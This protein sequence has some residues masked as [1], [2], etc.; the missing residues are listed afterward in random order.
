MSGGDGVSVQPSA[1]LIELSH[2]WIVLRASENVHH[3]VSESH[4]TL[5]DE[6]LGRFMHSQALHDLRNLFSRLSGTTGIAR[7]YR[8]RLT[9]RHELFDIA[10]HDVD[11]RVLLE[12]VPSP[13]HGL[14]EAFGIVGGLIEGLASATGTA[15]LEG[16]ARRMRA[17]TGFDRVTLLYGGKRAVS[18][19]GEFARE[20]SS[21]LALPPIIG[22]CGARAVPL[23]PRARSRSSAASALLRAAPREA[24]DDLVAAGIGA[25]DRDRRTLST[26]GDEESVAAPSRRERRPAAVGDDAQQP[27]TEITSAVVRRQR[28]ERAHQRILEHVFGIVAAPEHAGRIAQANR[29]V[30]VDEDRERVRIACQRPRDNVRVVHH[31]EAYPRPRSVVT[32]TARPVVADARCIER[33]VS[34]HRLGTTTTPA[35]PPKSSATGAVPGGASQRPPSMRMFARYAPGATCSRTTHTPPAVRASA[36]G[37]QRVNSPEISTRCASGARSEKR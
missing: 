11:G 16:A 34:C 15:L 32:C 23:F 4:V 36:T 26:V 31:I 1:C 10:F 30:A 27:G 19:R 29:G 35:V 5:I 20:A 6:P 13:D 25:G 21:A 22:D 7:A 33:D 24:L 8:V 14:G 9:D 28:A 3:L 12:A 18:S 17:L 37:C 2:D